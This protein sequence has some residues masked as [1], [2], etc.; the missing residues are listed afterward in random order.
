MDGWWC[1]IVQFVLWI[2]RFKFYLLGLPR[3]RDHNITHSQK[4]DDGYCSPAR[5]FES[6]NNKQSR[7]SA[8][9]R[10][11]R[12][13]RL[14]DLVTMRLICDVCGRRNA[15][16]IWYTYVF[17]LMGLM[18]WLLRWSRNEKRVHCTTETEDKNKSENQQY[19]LDTHYDLRDHQQDVFCERAV[20]HH[21][22][23]HSIKGW[24]WQCT[25]TIQTNIQIC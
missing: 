10:R 21:F 16:G 12:R 8:W 13:R 1:L 5:C 2:K 4:V 7:L 17:V 11:R 18:R 15:Y 3:Q 14:G 20:I 25:Q 24:R 9:R 6:H 22:S 23:A 19:A